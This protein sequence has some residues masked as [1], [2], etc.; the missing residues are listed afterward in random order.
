M[1]EISSNE[2]GKSLYVANSRYGLNQCMDSLEKKGISVSYSPITCNEE[3]Y[4]NVPRWQE[5]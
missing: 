5:V 2:T 4:A 1:F 3:S